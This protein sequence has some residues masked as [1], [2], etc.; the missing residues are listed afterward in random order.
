MPRAA[1]LIHRLLT[2]RGMLLPLAI[3][4]AVLASVVGAELTMA[5]D[6]PSRLA[7]APA[8]ATADPSIARQAVALPPL[9]TFPEV[10]QRPLFSEN[11]LPAAVETTQ[12]GDASGPLALAGTVISNNVH[13]AL[14]AVGNPPV[15]TRFKEGQ[16]VDGWSI[17]AIERN[18]VVLRRGAEEREVKFHDNAAAAP[19][20]NPRPHH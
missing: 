6:E 1:I 11:R 16:T 5:G 13:S 14:F 15:L 17:R 8:A 18:R 12:S 20:E 9:G 3:V 7:V 10:T 2:P 19:A 4:C